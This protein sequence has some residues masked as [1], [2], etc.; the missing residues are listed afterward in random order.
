M[1]AAPIYIETARAQ[2]YL[3]GRYRDLAK[4]AAWSEDGHNIK[5]ISEAEACALG[6]PGEDLLRDGVEIARKLKLSNTAPGSTETAV[7][8]ITVNEAVDAVMSKILGVV[9]EVNEPKGRRGYTKLSRQEVKEAFKL[10]ALVGAALADAYEALRVRKIQ[11]SKGVDLGPD[12]RAVADAIGQAVQGLWIDG[13]LG[14]EGGYPLEGF[15]IEAHV[16][17]T[18]EIDIR[19]ALALENDPMGHN[20]L[21]EYSWPELLADWKAE[22]SDTAALEKIVSEHLTDLRVYVRGADFGEPSVFGVVHPAYFCG[23]TKDG[24]IAGGRSRVVWT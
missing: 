15:H 11:I 20:D 6:R 8:D 3:G 4:D 21:Y 18:N 12:S 9:K 22:G 5:T 14:S 23:V 10:N 1:K 7:V 2:R 16:D 19:Q 13:H 17:S 24:S